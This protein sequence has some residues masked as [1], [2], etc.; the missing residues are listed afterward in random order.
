MTEIPDKKF[1]NIL[2]KMINY[3]KDDLNKQLNEEVSSRPG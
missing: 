2:S 3:L 1:K